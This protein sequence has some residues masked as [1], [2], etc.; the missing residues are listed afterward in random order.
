MPRSPIVPMV[1]ALVL[2]GSLFALAQQNY[3]L[4]HMLVELSTVV[5]AACGFAVVWIARANIENGFLLILGNALLPVSGLIILHAL[6]YKG[7]GVFKG[8][9]ANPATQLW[10]ASRVLLSSSMALGAALIEKRPKVWI[11]LGLG[12]LAALGLGASILFVPIFPACFVEGKGLTHFKI[13]MEYGIS[14]LLFTSALLL[15]R[16]RD[17][18]ERHVLKALIVA[19]GMGVA[20]EM[21]FTLYTDVYGLM[22]LMGHLLCV[23]FF[24]L[25]LQALVRTGIQ[26]PQ[27]LLLREIVFREQAL[28]DSEALFSAAFYSNSQAMIIFGLSDGRIR[29]VNDGFLSL[30][31]YSRQEVVGRT[32][33]ELDLWLDPKERIGLMEALTRQGF[34]R[35]MECRFKVRSGEVRIAEL[36]SQVLELKGEPL[37][38]AV[39][40]DLTDQRRAEEGLRD[41]LQKTREAKLGLEKALSAVTRSE[42]EMRALLEGST[43]ILRG[44]ELNST[45]R[46]LYELCKSTLGAKAGFVSLLSQDGNGMEL[47]FLDLGDEEC[48]V[49]PQ[50]PMPLRGLKA[51]V[52]AS[53]APRVENEFSSTPFASLVPSGHKEIH[54]VLF[55]PLVIGNEG[56]GLLALCNKPGG[57]T[58]KDV[59]LAGAFGEL[60]AIAVQNSRN[61]EALKASEERFRSVVDNARDAIISVDSRGRIILWNEAAEKLFGYTSGEIIGEPVETIIP[62]RF[63]EAHRKGMLRALSEFQGPPVSRTTELTAKRKDGSEFPVEVSVGHWSSQGEVFFTGIVRDITERVRTLEALRKAYDKLEEE[64]AQRTAQLV[65]A[66]QALRAEIQ[67]RARIEEKLKQSQEELRRLS[68]A[69]LGAQEEERK[70]VAQ[71]IHDSVGQ[72]LAAVKFGTERAL[73]ELTNGKGDQTRFLLQDVIAMVQGAIEEVRRIQMDLRPTVLDDLGL[74]AA[75]GWFCREFQKVYSYINIEKRVEV[76]EGDVPESLKIVIFRLLQE[77]L[78]NV[79]KHS[80]ADRTS[81]SLWASDSELCL[82]IEDNGK[83]IDLNQTAEMNS[84]L[85][86]RMGILGMRERVELSGGIFSLDSQPGKGTRVKAR[87]PL[88]QI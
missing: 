70:Q 85:C 22:N 29:E 52:I 42:K 2:F 62:E 43:T 8:M 86:G 53:K 67:W 41:A 3:L 51:Q 81:V 76:E 39:A 13:W 16:A 20:S 32:S 6:A 80:E 59:A 10:I 64:V 88:R 74:V 68:W 54:N 37:A 11:V 79:A 27:D 63:K 71:E 83:G 46:G 84:A 60:A 25:I 35:K 47:L 34:V 30:T 48:R 50:L 61:L 82:E 4:F 65:E 12:S 55:A 38:L 73:L 78:N 26:R 56:V 23:G 44:M 36:D 57:F 75:I 40:R 7:M 31:G 18:F 58:D 1:C 15:W 77:A 69:I 49:S 17:R 24:A 19:A 5:I 66:N 14:A 21:S 72:I 28:R 87:W 33:E 45:I 9:D